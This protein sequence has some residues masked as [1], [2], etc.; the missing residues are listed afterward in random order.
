[1]QRQLL[2]IRM[3]NI[4][5]TNKVGIIKGLIGKIIIGINCQIFDE[6]FLL[7]MFYSTKYKST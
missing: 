6:F 3:E 5:I 7:F 1:M 2:V 4:D